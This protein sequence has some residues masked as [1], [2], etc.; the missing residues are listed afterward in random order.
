MQISTSLRDELKKSLDQLCEKYGA[1]AATELVR[2]FAEHPCPA[3]T[4]AERG[5]NV[6]N[7]EIF[8]ISNQR[9]LRA[10]ENSRKRKS[11]TKKAVG[12]PCPICKETILEG[13]QRNVTI[14]STT[15]VRPRLS[16]RNATSDCSRIERTVEAQL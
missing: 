4:D 15:G 7:H 1:L 3:L 5:Q 6:I 14:P 2:S 11:A 10:D 16:I 8:K 13:R 12:T 9:K